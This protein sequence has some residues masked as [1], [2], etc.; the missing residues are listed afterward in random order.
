MKLGDLLDMV[1]RLDLVQGVEGDLRQRKRKGVVALVVAGIVQ[2]VLAAAQKDYLREVGQLV[3]NLATGRWREIFATANLDTLFGVVVL[4]AGVTIFILVR[5]SRFLLHES[6]A[7]FR[8][9]FSIAPFKSMPEGAPPSDDPLVGNLALLHDDLIDKLNANI[10]RFSIL[11]V[12]AIKTAASQDLSSHIHVH[13]HFARRALDSGEDGV[14]VMTRIRIGNPERPEQQAPRVDFATTDATVTPDAQYRQLRELVY[15]R[16]ATAIYHQI[17][18]DIRQKI[19]LFPT[20]SLRAVGLYHEAKDFEESNTVD[21]YD[22]AIELYQEALNAFEKR[23]GRGLRA[24]LL[25][26]PLLWRVVCR[27]QLIEARTRIAYSRC[28][29]Y[30]ATVSTL[31]GRAS[32]PLFPVPEQLE[33][34]LAVLRTLYD[35]ARGGRDTFVTYPRAWRASHREPRFQEYRRAL[36]EALSV[37]S[38]AWSQI[39]S[40]DRAIEHLDAAKDVAPDLTENDALYLLAQAETVSDLHTRL[41][42]LRTASDMAPTFEIVRYRLADQS[43]LQL[44]TRNELTPERAAPVLAAFLDVLRINP[45]NIGAYAAF[46]H[47]KWL[48]GDHD[49]ASRAFREGLAVKAIRM[50]TYVGDLNYGLARIAAEAG[51]FNESFDLYQKALAADPGVGVHI[52]LRTRSLTRYYDRMVDSMLE[53]Y[54]R[55]MTTAIARGGQCDTVSDRTLGGVLSFVL[56]DYGNAAFQYFVRTGQVACCDR[57]RES[58]QHAIK[59][60]PENAVAYFN[61]SRTLGWTG[62]S[63]EE[64]ITYLARAER[65]EPSWHALQTYSIEQHITIIRKAIQSL[66]NDRNAALRRRSELERER[67]ELE[68]QRASLDENYEAQRAPTT[69]KYEAASLTKGPDVRGRL[70]A[71]LQRNAEVQTTVATEI[72]TIGEKINNYR[73]SHRTEILPRLRR[74]IRASSLSSFLDLTER[75][76]MTE[77]VASLLQ[78]RLRNDRLDEKSATTLRILAKLMPDLLDDADDHR[79]LE[80]CRDFCRYVMDRF[81]PEDFELTITLQN[82]Y[83]QL[84]DHDGEIA[85]IQSVRRAISWAL[86]DDGTNWNLLDWALSYFDRPLFSFIRDDE[87]G[88]ALDRAF[89]TSD[90]EAV[91]VPAAVDDLFRKQGVHLSASAMLR[92]VEA[93][94]HWIISDEHKRTTYSLARG[95]GDG[96]FDVTFDLHRRERHLLRA[97][98]NLNDIRDKRRNAVLHAM[99]GGVYRDAGRDTEAVIQ[100]EKAAALDPQASTYFTQLGN[101]HYVH[102]RYDQAAQAYDKATRLEPTSDTAFS[103]LALAEAA[104]ETVAHWQRALAALE[105]AAAL[106]PGSGKYDDRLAVL[107]EKLKAASC[108][109]EANLARYPVVT[110]IALE[111]AADLVP[112]VEGPPDSSDIS[113]T[114]AELIR[115]MRQGI[116]DQYGVRIPGVRVRGNEGDMVL[117]TYLIM[118]NEVPLVMQSVHVDAA[119]GGAHALGAIVAQLRLVLENNLAGFVGVQEVANLLAEDDALPRLEGQSLC[120][121]AQ[122]LRALVEERVSIKPLGALLGC[123]L[124]GSATN[125]PLS[126][127]VEQMRALADVTPSLPGTASGERLLR[128]DDALTARLAAGLIIEGDVAMLRGEPALI[129]DT[130]AA[131]REAT[132]GALVG[133][134]SVLVV[135]DPRL[136]R[137]LRRI[138]ELEF[139]DLPVLARSELPPSVSA[140]TAQTIGGTP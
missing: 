109:G 78:S 31:A 36:F 100:Y 118:V 75:H 81:Y 64:S 132:S 95:S 80:C 30:R 15:S 133:T 119:T 59:R 33:A 73:E 126:V 137:P 26:W 65:L 24:A 114:L 122:V 96:R 67:A 41:Q 32:N 29:V 46:G 49:A 82:L 112:F 91:L 11:D 25:K 115:Q 113:M 51:R 5:W 76:D 131:V 42:L 123:F 6:Q 63:T 89:A 53:R 20:W 14:Q 60:F 54:E 140:D 104:G 16:V 138:V 130:L 45:G 18:D 7:P 3:K 68:T 56:N 102:D 44:R 43:D 19:T 111:V 71:E 39:G 79:K 92:T 47:L 93:G 27:S 85:S 117:G 12:D 98:D 90:N 10:R 83:V 38:L 37:A 125:T 128:F 106:V 110:P 134:A 66:E 57:A 35:R 62:S 72:D 50:Q 139:T 116:Q 105:L 99:L 77:S 21:A 108:V 58:Y 34:A 9:T 84:G 28:L 17:R 61:L 88:P 52:A 55:F 74:M 86:D 135:D 103:N 107:R 2:V 120:A 69:A 13:G 70:D 87:T 8:Y 48:L 1:S 136:R 94:R 97:L 127:I 101:H 4:V 40:T 129:Q 22:Y 121:F 23:G 124:A